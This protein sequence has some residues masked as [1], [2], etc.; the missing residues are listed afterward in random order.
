MPRLQIRSGHGPRLLA[1]WQ[2]VMHTRQNVSKPLV[3]LVPSRAVRDWLLSHGPLRNVEV[4]TLTDWVW[5]LVPKYFRRW[6]DRVEHVLESL[7]PEAIKRPLARD[8]PGLYLTVIQ[9]AIECRKQNIFADNLDD[10]D[11]AL[12]MTLQ[13]LDRDV[14]QGN[15]YDT[16]RL[17]QYASKHWSVLR[18]R[19][20]EIIFWGFVDFLPGEWRLIETMGRHQPCTVYMLGDSQ[21]ERWPPGAVVHPLENDPKPAT[22]A[23][24]IPEKYLAPEAVTRIVAERRESGIRLQDLI[25]VADEALAER[26]AAALAYRHIAVRR[27]PQP[28]YE[29]LALWRILCVEKASSRSWRR[30]K[31]RYPDLEDW[32]DEWDAARR[33]VT[34]WDQA[35]QLVKTATQRIPAL[36]NLRMALNRWDALALACPAPSPELLQRELAGLASEWTEP[37]P[38]PIDAVWVV[39]A[40]DALAMVGDEFFIPSEALGD[41]S[42]APSIVGVMSEPFVASWHARHAHQGRR[43]RTVLFH[44]ARGQMWLFGE[45][46]DRDFSTIPPIEEPEGAALS[47]AWYTDW[48]GTG[49]FHEQPGQAPGTISVSDLERFG[50]CPRAFFF[51]RGL[52][53][54][55]WIDDPMRQWPSLYGQWA[56][57]ALYYLAQDA[58]LSVADAVQRAIHTQS[59]P[60]GILDVVVRQAQYRLIANLQ[61]VW[62]GI[63]EAQ[64]VPA[65]TEAEVDWVWDYS[66][67]EDQWHIRMRLDRIEHYGDHDVVV[68]FKTGTLANPEKVLADRLQIPVYLTAWRARYPGRRVRGVLWGITDKNHFRSREVQGD[69]SLDRKTRQVVDG[70]LTRISRGQFF[71]APDP[72]ADPCRFCDYRA[73]CP[74]NVRQMAQIKLSHHPEFRTL[75]S[76]GNA[77]TN[78]E[79]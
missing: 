22:E 67:A 70:I 8:I 60:E 5:S 53:L 62:A 65:Q 18:S 66:V 68:D 56:H 74:G 29:V 77:K 48:Y 23:I 13:W 2:H 78:D 38:E 35:R 34:G 44:A 42:A 24:R 40:S 59:P 15:L 75:W 39:R 21:P 30:L 20:T 51:A 32:L 55:P 76:E 73:L 16:V 26:I 52:K 61:Y 10:G 72:G 63:Q 17:Y 69:E 12:Q 33:A 41:F 9:A 1:D 3:T 49:E 45:S 14:F 11:A 50:S 54:K 27:G 47:L 43:A 4:V 79:A 19:A 57:L 31:D 71:P 37:Q 46:G 6:P 7:L 64:E 58:R 25:V 28:S 36:R